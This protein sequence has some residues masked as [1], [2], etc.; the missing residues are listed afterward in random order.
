MTRNICIDGVDNPQTIKEGCLMPSF[1]L[2]RE[3]VDLVVDYLHS[4]K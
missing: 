2:S 1:K 4:L 3:E